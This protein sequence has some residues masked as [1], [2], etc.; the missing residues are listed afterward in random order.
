MSGSKASMPRRDRP[1][2]PWVP[3]KFQLWGVYPR[4]RQISVRDDRTG[5]KRRQQ[6]KRYDVRFHVDGYEVR[7]GF[8]RKGWADEFA[9]QLQQDFAAG[10]H[11]DPAARR[12]I[13]AVPAT[14]QSSTSRAPTF[15]EHAREYF[16]RQWH[17][18]EPAT[19]QAAQGP[20]ARACIELVHGEAPP[21]DGGQRVRA[22]AYLR[23][24]VFIVPAADHLA[25]EDV[26]WADWFDKWSLPL[27]EIT[28]LHL[29]GFIDSFRSAALDGTP[30]DVKPATVQRTRAVVRAVFTNARK[31]RLLLWDPWEALEAENVKDHDKVDPDLV[32]DPEETRALA[33]ACARVDPRYEAYVLIQGFCGPR[34]G[35][36]AD[37]RLRDLMLR[38]AD[39]TVTIGGSHS[40]VPSRF[41]T[42]GQERR[43]PLKG[44]GPKARRT[45]P[46]PAELVDV[47][48]S[49]VERFV[50]RHPDA[51][52]FTTSRGARIGSSNFYRAVWNV[53]REDA[54]PEGSPLRRVR[55]H[56][57]RHSAIT[58]WLNAGVP[59]KTAQRWSGH[60][61]L[62]VLLDTYVGVMKGDEQLA[63][64]RVEAA[65]RPRARD[66]ELVTGS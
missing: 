57:L 37:L 32:M 15:F 16:K 59:L 13:A 56:D 2:E 55:R 53:A 27:D 3:A 4:T 63:R 65:L 47:L 48:Q 60:K 42:E 8:E 1:S 11:F 58:M 20:L 66:G 6:K 24:A 30:R 51:Y 49:H 25:D 62:S 12:F 19:R 26:R 36:A 31:R 41:F 45:V 21:L 14:S 38:G 5:E 35:E 43:R 50:D 44:R 28:D 39:P 33:S 54:F 23:R 64:E 22:D 34:P 52:L 61:T 46:I 40:E 10:L 29:R 17:R 9:R 7:Y 18:W